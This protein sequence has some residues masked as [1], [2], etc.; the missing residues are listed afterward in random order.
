MAMPR[1]IILVGPVIW[2]CAGVAAAI[3]FALPL[4]LGLLGVLFPV[5]IYMLEPLYGLAL[6]VLAVFAWR[7]RSTPGAVLF[8]SLLVCFVV[9][10]WVDMARLVAGIYVPALISFR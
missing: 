10:A 7:R 5:D 9:L 8:C 2:L 3:H 6:L 1:K 4:H